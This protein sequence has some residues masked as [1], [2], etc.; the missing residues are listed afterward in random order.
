MKI[1]RWRHGL[2]GNKTII[3]V[4]KRE[5]LSLIAK[6]SNQLHHHRLPSGRTEILTESGEF[7]DIQIDFDKE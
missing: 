6:L 1:L 2:T 3:R 7:F 5:A 4:T